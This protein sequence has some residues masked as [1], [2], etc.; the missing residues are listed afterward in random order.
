MTEQPIIPQNVREAVETTDMALIELEGLIIGLDLAKDQCEFVN[1][2]SPYARALHALLPL[3]QVT[4]AKLFELR[5]K[6]WIAMG[7]K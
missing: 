6:E 1:I 2:N 7:G 3:A 4:V 5:S